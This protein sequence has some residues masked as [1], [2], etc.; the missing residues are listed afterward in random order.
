MVTFSVQLLLI[1]LKTNHL[2]I[3]HPFTCASGQSEVSYSSSVVSKLEPASEPPR[4]AV[5]AGFVLYSQSFWFSRSGGGPRNLLAPRGCCCCCS[6]RDHTL[7]KLSLRKL[8][9]LFVLC[10]FVVHP[11]SA[12]GVGFSPLSSACRPSWGC[13]LAL[14]PSSLS[15]AA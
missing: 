9:P 5:K 11:C 1:V 8:L 4:E 14:G 7:R 13:S 10:C 3:A 6:S 15:P 12:F 2:F